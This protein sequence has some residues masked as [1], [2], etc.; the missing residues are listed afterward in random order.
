MTKQEYRKLAL[1]LRDSIPFEKRDKYSKKIAERLIESESVKKA[2][3]I[4]IYYSYRSEVDTKDLIE[5]LIQ[6][7]KKVF[8]PKVIDPK[9]G[10]MEFYRITDMDQISEGFHGIPEPVTKDAYETDLGRLH[11]DTLMIIPGVA[12]DRECN[13]IGSKGGFYDRYIPRVPGAKLVAIA[14]DEQIF[15]D[16]FPM[17]SYDMKPDMIISQSRIDI[18]KS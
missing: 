5:R 13:R 7:G 14:F 16:V 9:E 17:E 1:E 15:D 3:N 2:E 10:I 11:S 4:L 12:F 18:F 8:C 6:M